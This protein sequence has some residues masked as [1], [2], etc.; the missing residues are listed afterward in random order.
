MDEAH[1]IKNPKTAVFKACAELKAHHRWCLTGTPIQ[2]HLNDC[3]AL[4]RFLRYEVH[5]YSLKSYVL[6]YILA[7]EFII[8]V[9]ECDF[10]TL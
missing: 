10:V 1:S 5:N 8:M 4:L 9:E 6:M 3:H 7:M 2:N